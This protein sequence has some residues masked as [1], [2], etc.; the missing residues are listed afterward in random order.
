M[1]L[2]GE[3]DQESA[4]PPY[5]RNQYPASH[6]IFCFVGVTARDA[7]YSSVLVRLLTDASS[8]GIPYE[9]NT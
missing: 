6:V 1:E 3:F 9:N 2:S 7:H 5:Q 4:A 8:G